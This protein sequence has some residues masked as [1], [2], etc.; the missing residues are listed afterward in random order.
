MPGQSYEALQTKKNQLIRKALNGSVFTAQASAEAVVALTDAT[1][2]LLAPLPTGYGDLGWLTDDGAQYSRSVDSSDVTSWG[3][4]E[5]TRSDI[6]KDQT[7]LKVA[8]QET[9]LQTIGLYTGAD[10]TGITPDAGSGEVRIAKPLTPK[11]RY[12]RV[13][14]VA[15]DNTE[16]G[17][18]YIARFL[19]RAK[20]S[21]YDDQKQS[22]GDDPILW[23]VTFTSSL[24]ATLGFSEQHLFG[25]P[26]WKALLTDMGFT[27][28]GA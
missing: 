8:C 21:D 4:T 7:E 18:I 3:S 1:S 2:S 28:G 10:T 19:P 6:T 5:P 14:S 22:S 26:G 13:L 25:G 17:E 27:T 15:V 24:D 9:K 16:D 12:Y 20:V 23:G 11:A